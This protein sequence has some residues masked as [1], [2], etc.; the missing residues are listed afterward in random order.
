MK[1]QSKLLTS[2]QKE[3]LSLLRK[4]L[5]N[6]E[7]CR[8]LNISANTVKV[9][10]AN[11]YKA[12]EVTNRTEAVSTDITKSARRQTTDDDIHITITG[13]DGLTATPLAK[14][15]SLAIVEAL[16]HYHLFRIKDSIESQNLHA[17]R[18]RR[19]SPGPPQRKRT[20]SPGIVR[21][22]VP[23]HA[24]GV[25]LLFARE[26]RRER[27]SR[28]AGPAI[29]SRDAPRT[30]TRPT[31]KSSRDGGSP[32]ATPISRPK[33]AAGNP[34]TKSFRLWKPCSGKR[35]TTP[36]WP[37]RSFRPTTRQSTKLG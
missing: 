5:T 11:I 22:A 18:E 20:V 13:C 19:K 37:V 8:A 2:R 14:G 25:H 27:G 15:L 28:K 30:P 16:H 34:S 29:P 7:I 3:I 36:T 17:R 9:H 21:Q 35:T 1:D 12:L 33:A 26:I 23:V 24:K 10:L 31:G 4:G 6:S 32:P